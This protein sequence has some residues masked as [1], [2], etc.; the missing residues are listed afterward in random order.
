MV[1]R[2]EREKAQHRQLILEAA[3]V[4]F[5]EKDFHS[6]TVHE[7]AER[8]EFSVGYLYNLFQSKE[9]VFAELVDMRA[10]QYV[11]EVENRLAGQQ[12][13]R[14]KV[15]TVIRAKLDFFQRNRRFFRIFSRLAAAGRMEGPALLPQKV[16]KRYRA[17][18]QRLAQV[19]EEGMQSGVFARVDPLRLVLC[20]EGMTNAAI[21]YWVHGGGEEPEPI[22][23]D[24][25]ERVIFHGILAKG[26]E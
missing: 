7:I 21:A 3:E 4:V 11:A 17:F 23:P 19:F 13:V 8:A 6:A 25:V 9:E 20:M 14:E 16:S 1:T 24:I 18:L 2:R 12:D 26:A 10:G 22:A 5:A 15:R